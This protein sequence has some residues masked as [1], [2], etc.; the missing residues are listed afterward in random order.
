MLGS[1]GVHAFLETSSAKLR[2]SAAAAL[3]FAEAEAAV[4]G[5]ASGLVH[6]M[7]S[8]PDADLAISSARL[9]LKCGR[10]FW[11]DLG[12]LIGDA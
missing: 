3:S 8:I 5:G 12:I 10:F 11:S 1:C 4:A 9:L 6:R 2:G 7:N